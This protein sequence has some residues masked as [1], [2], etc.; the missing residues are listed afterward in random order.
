MKITR[1]TSTQSETFSVAERAAQWGG[2]YF[3]Y[4]GATVERLQRLIADAHEAIA[5]LEREG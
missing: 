4:E 1:I 3:V 2:T 5:S